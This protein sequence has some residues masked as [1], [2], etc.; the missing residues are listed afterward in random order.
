V[1][2]SV[3]V[4]DAQNGRR[5][6]ALP[7]RWEQHGSD[8][9]FLVAEQHTDTEAGTARWPVPDPGGR[10]RCVLDTD[11]YFTVLGVTPCYPEIVMALRPGGLGAGRRLTV[12]IAPHAYLVHDSDG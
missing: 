12:V 5:V 8:G 3:E 4:I 9:W 1:T 7:I 11:R 6:A 2:I 10:Y